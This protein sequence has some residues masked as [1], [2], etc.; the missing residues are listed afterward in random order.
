MWII[1]KSRL[2][3]YWEQPKRAEV[4]G[5][6]QAW[7]TV[8]SH[9]SWE[10]FADLKRTYGNAS[11]VGDCVVFNIAG[12]KYRLVTRVRY[13]AHKV[14]VLKIMTH[15]EYDVLD[16]KAECGCFARDEAREAKGR[17]SSIRRGNRG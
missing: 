1:S 11:L 14:Y 5:P 10:S 13:R 17:Q 16:W 7:H 15:A 12:N 8:V 2:R 3:D 4:K 9:A 6:L